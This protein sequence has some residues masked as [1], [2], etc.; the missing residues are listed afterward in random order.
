VKIQPGAA[1]VYEVNDEYFNSVHLITSVSKTVVTTWCFTKSITWL[2]TPK[3][4]VQCFCP[5]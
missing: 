5:A 1:A 4:F 3:E 2:G